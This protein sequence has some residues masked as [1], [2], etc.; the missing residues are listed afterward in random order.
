MPPIEPDLDDLPA[1]LA[2]R[3]HVRA[4]LRSVHLE[5][6]AARTEDGIETI[7]R[8]LARYAELLPELAPELAALDAAARA[9]RDALAGVY[10]GVGR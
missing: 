2:A 10:A 6:F 1:A 3:S 8:A 4:H 5:D 9:A 7:E